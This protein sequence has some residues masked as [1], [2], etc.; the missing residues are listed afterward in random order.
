MWTALKGNAVPV[1]KK[2][3]GET[4]CLW[5]N[6]AYEVWHASIEKGGYSSRHVHY[7]KFNDFY[8]F[9][10]KL[11]IHLYASRSAMEPE[12]TVTLTANQQFM[13]NPGKWH[14]FEAATDVELLEIYKGTAS[15][16]DIERVDEGGRKDGNDHA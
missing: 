10:G 2:P 7:S 3:W 9:R 16:Y 6:E 15:A 11:L 12:S 1:I 8:V 14:K 13:V 4:R 5:S